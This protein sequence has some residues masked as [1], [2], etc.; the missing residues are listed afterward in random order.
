MTQSIINI[1]NLGLF[2][3][4][5]M[6]VSRLA[7]FVFGIILIVF[8]MKHHGNCLPEIKKRTYVTSNG[9][10]MVKRFFKSKTAYYSNGTACFNFQ[11][12]MLAGDVEVNPGPR[13]GRKKV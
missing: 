5:E 3:G 13:S 1:I 8:F 12:L 4:T 6:A 10:F 7:S 2:S 9:N 11:L